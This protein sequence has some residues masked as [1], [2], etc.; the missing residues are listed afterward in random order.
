MIKR[1]LKSYSQTTYVGISLIQ[2]NALSSTMHN[3]YTRKSEKNSLCSKWQ[4]IS[5]PP[6]AIQLWDDF[7]GF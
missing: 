4:C 2:L 3:K 1:G 7:G 6:N 5:A